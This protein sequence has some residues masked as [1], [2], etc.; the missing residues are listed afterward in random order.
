MSPKCVMN[1]YDKVYKNGP[2]EIC[3][4]QPLKMKNILH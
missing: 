4:R 2:I 1:K 3:G